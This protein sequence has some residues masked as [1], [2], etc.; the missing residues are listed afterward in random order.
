MEAVSGKSVNH[1]L[2]IANDR[3]A[4]V[5]ETH[6]AD[7]IALGYVQP[8][9]DEV[10]ALRAIESRDDGTAVVGLAIAIVV[11]GQ[12]HDIARVAATDQQVA[13]LGKAQQAGARKVPGVDREGKPRRQLEVSLRAL[14]IDAGAG[15]ACHHVEN[16]RQAIYADGARGD[17]GAP[18]AD[19]QR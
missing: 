19:Q 10:H 16:H 6:P 4:V 9:A 18:G 1:G 11:P 14:L 17:Q 5:I 8:V 13:A 2:I 7:T 12:Q 3:A 15:P